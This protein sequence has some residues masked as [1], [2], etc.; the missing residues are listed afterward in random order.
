MEQIKTWSTWDV[1]CLNAVMKVPEMMEIR[2][3]LY[4]NKRKQYIDQMLW[5]YVHRFG[6]HSIDGSYFDME[7]KY[8]DLIY[9][10]EFAAIDN[11]F[12]YKITP[13]Q[14][15]PRIKFFICGLF[16]WHAK[17]QIVCTDESI[18]MTAGEQSY[19]ITVVGEIDKTTV[20]NTSQQGILLECG[21]SIYIRC[22]HDLSATEM[23]SFL[24]QKKAA[25]LCE[26]ISGGGIL[27]DAP[28]AII[29]G[30]TWNTIYEPTKQRFC[31]PVTREWCVM[32]NMT[33]FGGYV[34]FAWDTFLGGLLAA[35]Q[36]KELAYRQVYSVLE[37]FQ[38]DFAPQYGSQVLT[39]FDRSNPPVG[40]YCILKIYKQF[41]EKELL[42]NVFDKM[43][44]WNRWWINNRDGNGDG[45]LEWGSNRP[46][47]EN[48]G[49]ILGETFEVAAKM[50]SG[51][52]NSPMYDDVS[53]IPEGKTLNI[54]DIGLSSLYAMDCWALAEIAREIGRD[55][56]AKE[57]LAEYAA[58]KARINDELWNESLGIYCN[59]HWDGH[60]SEVLTP[61]SFYPLIA[62][63][64]SQAQAERMIKEHLLN[65]NEFW[66]ELVL[67]TVMKSH[68]AFEDN[69]YWRGR[70]WGPTNFLVSE[71][72][73]R[74]GYYDLAYEIA[75][76]SLRL[77]LGEW[78]KDNHIHENY[79][80]LTGDGDDVLNADPVYTWGGLLPYLA[81]EELVE[82][83][84]WGG[85]R[86]GNL[87][88]EHASLAG[89][90]FG[91]DIYKVVKETG[92]LIIRNDK[93]YIQTD[94]VVR[95]TSLYEEGACLE[96]HMEF[97]QNGVLEISS[98]DAQRFIIYLN[99]KRH[100]FQQENGEV[101]VVA[102]EVQ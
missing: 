88:E 1:E 75:Q 35:L 81:V 5:K 87:S 36:S 58:V 44:L 29:K 97:R 42:N 89:I 6:E 47:V 63:I 7:L 57:L 46:F 68:P 59:K 70:I 83:Q 60:F 80:A 41:Q 31:T 24:A 74:Y 93:P 39:R 53:F 73:K 17:G 15:L 82:A 85:L 66:G 98:G 76:K 30:M 69:D 27:E 21:T 25:W 101:L 56:E 26:S 4:D 61:T 67:P 96:F 33:H 62:G 40:S 48:A 79:N 9:R 91:K 16:R 55:Q 86:F 52:D 77:F 37:E 12:V 3:A 11:T 8:E 34:L 49:K 99:G 95:I 102:L 22:N 94:I 92:L 90:T 19:Q 28:Q 65:E 32:K 50:E 71:G 38:A 14:L 84:P 54:T 2:I 64:A 18:L 45:L 23:D 13:N 51:L 43:L 20:F 10:M 78:K 100:E 72:L